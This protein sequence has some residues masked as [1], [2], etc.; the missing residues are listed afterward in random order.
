MNDVNELLVNF[1]SFD[2]LMIWSGRLTT[3]MISNMILNLNVAHVKIL[4]NPNVNIE[5]LRRRYPTN[6]I[7]F[8]LV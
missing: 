5:E 3:D 2:E 7:T 8:T 4:N 1:A 6:T